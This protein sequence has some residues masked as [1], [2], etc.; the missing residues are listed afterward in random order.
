MCEKKKIAKKTRFQD[1]RKLTESEA[2]IY[3]VGIKSVQSVK[4]SHFFSLATI[5]TVIDNRNGRKLEIK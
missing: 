4:Q 5:V 1:N 3:P 2:F